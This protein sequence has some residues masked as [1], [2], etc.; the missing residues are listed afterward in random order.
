MD[1]SK[2]HITG[3]D[4]EVMEEPSVLDYVRS[5]LN[6]RKWGRVEIPPPG[7]TGSPVI[8]PAVIRKELSDKDVGESTLRKSSKFPLRTSAALI[9]ALAAQILLE[10]PRREATAAACL[11]GIS[12]FLLVWAILG[13]EVDAAPPAPHSERSMSLTFRSKALWVILPLSLVTFFSFGGNRF[14]GLNV[15]LWTILLF[16][17]FYAFWTPDPN[18]KAAWKESLAGFIRQPSIH[19]EIRPFTFLLI[20]ALVLSIFFRFYQIDQIPGEM[21]SDHAEKLLDVA[22]VLKGDTSI[23]FPRNTGREAFQMYL[24]AAVS[25]IFGTGLSFMS[26][27]IGTVLAGLAALPY[28]F[29]LGKEMG[30]RWTGLL[31]MI[32]AGIAYWPNVT[33]R[34]ALR[35]ALF[36]CFTAP[37]L[38][39]LIRGLRTSR[40]NDL[41]LSGLFLGIGLHGYSPMRIVP[42]VLMVGFLL[43]LVHGQSRGKRWQASVSMSLLALISL[44]VFLPLL[45]YILDDPQM[46]AFRA[47]SRMGETERAINGSALAVFA[48]N[49]WKASIMFFWDNGSIWVHSIPG[50][51]ALDSVTAALFFLGIIFLIARYL[52]TRNWADLFLLVTIPLLMLPSVLSLAFPDENPSLNRTGG[53]YVSVFVIA[54]MGLEEI[55]RTLG[56]CGRTVT[57]SR[58]LVAGLAVALILVSAASNYDLVFSQFKDQFLRGAWN[59]S[60]MGHLIR[61]FADSVGSPDSAYVVPYAHWVDTRLVGINA[62]FPEK[63]YALWPENFED[64]K[65]D[66][67][68]KL[69]LIKPEDS[70]AIEKL[71][72]LF[73]Q[74]T[75]W[76]Q[77][78]PYE[79][80]DFL[81]YFT[82]AFSG[83]EP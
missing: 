77:K 28:I 79:G 66:P 21:F 6:P 17:A 55:L 73:P 80:K 43:Y 78:G 47:F 2:N 59:T 32:L 51:P 54:A 30:S 40:R 45:R 81:V 25:I 33:S 20:G 65:E 82:P 83:S 49:L 42:I 38:Y 5:R 76:L 62:G 29:L 48:S 3:T 70:D 8:T 75:L 56:R 44:L 68:A 26:L 67:R 57:K 52:R 34:V 58:S 53:A 11:Y 27:K 16:S 39:Y 4:N 13:K 7:E 61:A 69:F 15:A 9:I 36:P 12:A 24:T 22:N 50:R 63:D 23:F 71:Q 18:H 1:Y 46:F 74:G 64:V 72:N 60:Q 37:A 19:F 10:P 35:F 14:T 41:L 31:A